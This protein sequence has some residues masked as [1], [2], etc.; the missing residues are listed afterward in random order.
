MQE[1]YGY[2][3]D[4]LTKNGEPWFPVMGEFHFSRYPEQYW[5]E[6]VYKMKAGGVDIVSTYVFWIHH[7]EIEGEYDFSGQRNLRKFTETVKDCGMKM[8]LRIGPWC[9]GEVRNGGFPD[10]LLKKEYEPRTNQEE[11]FAEVKKYYGEI[12]KQVEGLLWKDNGPIIGMQIENEYGHCGGLQGEEGEIHMKRLTC[13]AK[14]VG[15]MVTA[16]YCYRL[17]RCRYRRIAPGYGWIL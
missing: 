17:G 2:T 14:E 8:F 9:H 5:K 4:Y 10:W 15:L 3:K 6:S 1:N 7:E 13:I 12:A 16:L 11:Y